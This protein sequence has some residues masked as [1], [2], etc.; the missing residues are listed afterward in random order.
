VDHSYQQKLTP[1]TKQERLGA[2]SP[3]PKKILTNCGCSSCTN[4]CN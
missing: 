2:R 3:K 1:D 4:N